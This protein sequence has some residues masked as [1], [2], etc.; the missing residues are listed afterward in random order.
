MRRHLVSFL[1]LPVLFCLTLPV[2]AQ[3]AKPARAAAASGEHWVATWGTAM[4][5][6]PPPAPPAAG[7]P[8]APP[9]I[10]TFRDQTIRMIAPITIGGT[11]ARVHFSNAYGNL[12]VQF[13][14]VHVAL[15]EKDS[16]IVEGSD[17]TLT[18]GGKESIAISPGASVVSDPVDM[19]LP[20]MADVAVSVYLRGEAERPTRHAA[21]FHTTYISKE[22]DATGWGAIADAATSQSWYWLSGI[23]VA[24]TGNAAVLIAFGDS[25]TDGTRSTPDAN[26]SWPSI[27]AQ[28][29]HANAATSNIA[30]VNRG[31]AGNRLLREIPGVN[32]LA[33]FDTDVLGQPGAKWMIVL[34]GINDIG[35]GTRVPADAVTADDVIA[36]LNQ[37]VQ[38]AHIQGIRVFGG[39]LTPYEGAAYYS[40]VGEATRQA[41]NTW[42]RTSKVFD[43]VIDFEKAIRDPQNPKKVRAE[44]DSGDHLHPNDAG[45]KAMAQAIDLGLFTRASSQPGKKTASGPK[46]AQ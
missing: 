45:Y 4:Q 36:A 14:T 10:T 32:A 6:F 29:L 31:I 12:P 34:E 40:E 22:G 42:I 39:T 24:T 38:R 28:R 43:G 18:F 15:R 5:Q 46:T 9:V 13:A 26:R 2:F 19:Q 20:A 7:A 30:V 11:R 1:A 25:I 33:R 37:M 27:F 21:A 16:S 41:V 35:F 17:H 8:P 23:D 44:F 3:S